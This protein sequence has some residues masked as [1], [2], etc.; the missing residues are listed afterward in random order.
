MPWSEV[1]GRKRYVPS[2]YAKEELPTWNE[3]YNEFL[4]DGIFDYDPENPDHQSLDPYWKIPRRRVLIAII[5]NQFNKMMYEDKSA[6]I[7]Y[8]RLKCIIGQRVPIGA[9]S[10]MAFVLSNSA[11]INIPEDL[12]DY[13]L[14]PIYTIPLPTG[15]ENPFILPTN[16]KIIRLDVSEMECPLQLHFLVQTIALSGP[17]DNNFMVAINPDINEFYDIIDS[18]TKEIRSYFEGPGIGWK[19]KDGNII[20]SDLMK[21]NCGSGVDPAL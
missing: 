2:V 5:C 21:L 3:V 8:E 18:I 9:I 11:H 1:D 15:D 6:S 19:D 12:N 13:E 4:K 7:L 20:A 16:K 14:P 10:R 17:P